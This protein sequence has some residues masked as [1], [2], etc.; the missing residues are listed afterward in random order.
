MAVFHQHVDMLLS[1][2][3]HLDRTRSEFEANNY[4]ATTTQLT[5]S[6]V[7]TLLHSWAQV[8]RDLRLTEK[9]TTELSQCTQSPIKG[10][11]SPPS[12]EV[13]IEEDKGILKSKK[14]TTA[15]VDIPD[16]DITKECVLGILDTLQYWRP[17]LEDSPIDGA[18]IKTFMF[19]FHW[20]LEQTIL[21]SLDPKHLLGLLT[22]TQ[23]M[24]SSK[25]SSSQK[26]AKSLWQDSPIAGDI[27]AMLLKIYEKHVWEG[28]QVETLPSV[29]T[30][31]LLSLVDQGLKLCALP[32]SMQS[33]VEGENYKY[34]LKEV[35]LKKETS[36]KT[37]L[38]MVEHKICFEIT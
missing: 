16:N 36:G 2:L 38:Y 31:I 20:S 21:L 22:N 32:P 14:D 10:A 33:L 29:V 30:D 3:G 1:M 18:D 12:K 7:S 26:L 19:V 15:V 5:T 28:D 9:L 13:A 24:L 23:K 37:L 34:G 25:G 11:V 8:S 35:L 27:T 17:S 6:N 4:C